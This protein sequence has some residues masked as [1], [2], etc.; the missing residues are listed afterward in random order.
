MLKA[1]FTALDWQFARRPCTAATR[2]TFSKTRLR[3]DALE[4]RECPAA[5]SFAPEFSALPAT[6]T[7]GPIALTS[8]VVHGPQFGLVSLNPQPLPP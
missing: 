5:L 7:P 2:V 1:L 4:A 8:G 3:C 6:V